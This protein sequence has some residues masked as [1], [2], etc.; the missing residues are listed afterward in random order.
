MTLTTQ[1]RFKSA[2]GLAY[3]KCGSGPAIVLV[4]GVGLCAQAW[5]NQTS[6]LCKNNTVYAIDMPGHGESELLA[7]A[8][9]DLDEYVDAIAQWID[10]ELNTAVIM[11][12]HSMGSMIALRFAIA[13]PL[14]CRG[15][16]A[17]NSV[18][19]RTDQARI[20]VQQRAQSM[21]DNPELDRVS[22]PILRWFG[23]AP[24]G[25]I[26]QMAQLCASWLS[27]A[28]AIGYAKAYDIFS[29][30]DGPLDSELAS[31]AV[32]VAFIT[33]DLDSNS[34]GEMSQKMAHLTPQGSAHVIENSR[35]MVQ[36]THPDQINQLLLSFV[37]EC[38]QVHTGV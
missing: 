29:R 26:K 15:V 12:G 2:N 16:V 8:N 17:L 7:E 23:E 1:Q 32:P 25:H 20:A 11:M 21:L 22:T 19:R 14:L 36:L 35:H 38:Q 9:A 5:L 34:S 33:G 28:P 6:D 18:Y 27:E 3:T 4:H 31:I 24:T 30:N 37:N 13:Y 10:E